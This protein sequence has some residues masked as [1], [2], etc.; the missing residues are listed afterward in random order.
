[1][2]YLGALELKFKALSDLELAKN[3]LEIT[4]ANYYFTDWLEINKEIE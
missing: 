3:E 1:M 2:E 4:K